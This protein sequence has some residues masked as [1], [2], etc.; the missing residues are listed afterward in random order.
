MEFCIEDGVLWDFKH[1]NVQGDIII[2]HG[3]KV[4][5][6]AA[7]AHCPS[8]FSVIIPD[9]VE[10]IERDAFLDCPELEWVLIPDSVKYIGP[11][12]FANCRKLNNVSIPE[13]VTEINPFAFWIYKPW[14]EYL[15]GGP[16]YIYGK[17]GG[18]ADIFA[19]RH[20]FIF[21][22]NKADE[23]NLIIGGRVYDR[24]EL[25]PNRD[26]DIVLIRLDECYEWGIS[27]EGYP[28][29]RLQDEDD[30]YDRYNY[31]KPIPWIDLYAKIDEMILLA[32]SNGFRDWSDE[33]TRIKQ[34][35]TVMPKTDPALMRATFSVEMIQEAG[36]HTITKGT[37]SRELMRRAAQGVF[38]AYQSWK[39][40]DVVV[41]CGSDNNAGVGYAL[42]EILHDHGVKARICHVCEGFSEDGA[43]YY[44]RCMDKK[45]PVV[46]WIDIWVY[47]VYLD[48]MLGS[49]FRGIPREEI[50]E[51]I[52]DLNYARACY[53]ERVVISVGINSGIDGETGEAALAVASNLTV[54]VGSVPKGLLQ[55]RARELIGKLVNVDSDILH[56]QRVC[57]SE[58]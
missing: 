42:A 58:R 32:R 52:R 27:A 26:G 1:D 19:N 51:M 50:A 56:Q 34:M 24:P 28:F 12:A 29:E 25:T 53:R 36:R 40:K 48:C 39:G 10:R 45:I 44:Q 15:T 9:T 21:K 18:V 4:I 22:E 33:Y 17:R 7:F 30:P 2:P 41:A 13:S 38:D 5:G 43:Y 55:G 16:Y 46:E 49:S 37:P 47:D 35:V 54:S 20:C 3:V 31:F 8:L 57:G 11:Y 23:T 6:E 14:D